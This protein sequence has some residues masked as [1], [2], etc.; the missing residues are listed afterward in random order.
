LEG[1]IGGKLERMFEALD[2]TA[3]QVDEIG[4]TARWRMLV[5]NCAE[6]ARLTQQN[7]QIVRVADDH[8]DWRVA[9]CASSA[10]WSTAA[11]PRSP[12]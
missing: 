5:A 4:R 12:T 2:E 11:R 10:D 1:S 6:I 9:G 7:T 8:G 3:C